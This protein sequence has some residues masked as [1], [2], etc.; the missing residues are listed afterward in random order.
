MMITGWDLS[1]GL[2]GW[3]AGT[4]ETVPRASAFELLEK[5]DLGA[6]GCEFQRHVLM[7]HAAYPSTHW[8]VEQPLLLPRDR[9]HDLQRTY[10][11]TFLLLTLGAKLGIACDAVEVGTVKREFA[12]RGASKADMV[13]I[14]ERLGI[15][16]PTK[17][18]K[19]A[20]DASGVW[21]V[22]LRLVR[23]PHLGRWDKAVYQGQGRIL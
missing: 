10:G 5:H 6:L 2:C 11:I 12:G 4:G 1:P 15:D 9:R 7:V 3:C 8:F 18:R 19:D 16:L 21:K 22:G 23:S 20:A 14:A 13:R 17:G